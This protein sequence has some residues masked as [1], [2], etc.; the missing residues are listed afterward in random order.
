MAKNATACLLTGSVGNLT[1]YGFADSAEAKF[2]AFHVALH[3][4]AV[5]WSRTLCNHNNSSQITGRLTGFDHAS[6]FVVV[7]WNFRNQNDIG[8]A[9]DPAVQRDPTSMAPHYFH[10]H[11][12]LVTRCRC[13]HSI[14]R[15][16]HDSGSGIES[17]CRRRGFEIVVDGLRNADAI[18]TSFLQLLRCYHGAI[19]ADDDQRLY[20]KLAQYLLRVCNDVCRHSRLIAGTDFGHKMTAIRRADNRAAQRHHDPVDALAIENDV[21]PRGK[22]SFESIAKTNYFPAEFFRREHNAAQDRVKSRAIATAGQNTNPWL[23][24]CKTRIRAFSLD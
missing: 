22:K 19:A 10:Y 1:G 16:H 15:I 20:L 23:H 11:D 3:L 14:E 12:S 8:A 5:F 2:T 6:D 4:F 18:N 13:V 7:E 17:E 21:I 9:G 24:L